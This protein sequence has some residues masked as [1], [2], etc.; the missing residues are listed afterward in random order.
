MK[1][2]KFKRI[3]AGTDEKEDKKIHLKKVLVR[4]AKRKKMLKKY[5]NKKII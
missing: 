4:M 1:K 3:T 2:A 5:Q